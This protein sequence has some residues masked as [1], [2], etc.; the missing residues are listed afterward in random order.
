MKQ[1]DDEI[2]QYQH[3]Q[4]SKASYLLVN[5]TRTCLTNHSTLPVWKHTHS[6]ICSTW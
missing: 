3:T 5:C 4:P 1:I 2:H 6:H